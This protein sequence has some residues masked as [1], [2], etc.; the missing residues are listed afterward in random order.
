MILNWHVLENEN[1]FQTY[2][3]LVHSHYSVFNHPASDYF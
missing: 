3:D 2:I 1:E